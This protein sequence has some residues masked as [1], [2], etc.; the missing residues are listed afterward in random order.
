MVA[1]R[2]FAVVLS[3]VAVVA[4]AGLS[5]AA[6]T[7][8]P[9]ALKRLRA[10]L[11]DSSVRYASERTQAAGPYGMPVSRF[12]LRRATGSTSTRCPSRP[13]RCRPRRRS[14]CSATSR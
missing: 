13:L 4:W 5:Y 3:A 7:S 11:P 6:E 2:P 1:R 12:V 14:K 9:A 10:A 8:D